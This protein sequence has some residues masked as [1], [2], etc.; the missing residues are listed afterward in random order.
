MAILCY[1]ESNPEA[2]GGD[3]VSVART[4]TV[5]ARSMCW[6]G[7]LIV[8]VAVGRGARKISVRVD[9]PTFVDGATELSNAL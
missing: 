2:A 8:V 4:W 6:V 7:V 5:I 1:R 3:V 9:S